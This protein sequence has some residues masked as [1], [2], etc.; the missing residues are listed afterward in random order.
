M[1]DNH[2]QSPPG[3]KMFRL[4][5]A[6]S[7]ST[8]FAVIIFAF[9]LS[10]SL[11]A[12]PG[13]D[14]EIPLDLKEWR[15]VSRGHFRGYND[16]RDLFQIVHPM[17]PAAAGDYGRMERS[18]KLP[19]GAEAPYTL[20]FYVSDNI[21]GEVP[22]RNVDIRKGH[23]YGQV[24]LDGK[25]IWSRDIFVNS[26][27][28][29]PPYTWVDLTPYVKPG[30]L[31]NLSFQ[32][33]QEVDSSS[34]MEGDIIK[35]GVYAG[36]TR[37]Y[38]PLP[39][40]KY[41]TWSYW[42]DFSIFCGEIQE[43]EKM[44]PVFKPRIKANDM[45]DIYKQGPVEEKMVSLA[46]EKGE[47]LD[48]SWDWPVS[49]GIPLPSGAVRD[50]SGLSLAMTGGKPARAVFTPMGRWPD[51]SL[52][53]VLLDVL[54]GK[55]ERGNYRLL[56]GG[57]VNAPAQEAKD[58]IVKGNGKLEMGNGIVKVKWNIGKDGRPNDLEIGTEGGRK[59][60]RD[61]EPYM[62]VGSRKLKAA[63]KEG[64]WLSGSSRRS[65]MEISGELVADDGFRYG[66]CRMRIA[67][68]AD[69]P[70]LRVLYTVV[71]ER[72]E[73]VP[74]D[75]PDTDK[76][77][78]TGGLV[79]GTRP[80]TAVVDTYGLMLKCDVRDSRISDDGWICAGSGSGWV[81]GYL[82]YF[83]HIWPAGLKTDENGMDFILFKKGDPRLKSYSTYPGEAKTHEIWLA[84][85]GS[86][87]GDNLCESL[88]KIAETP[89][90]LDTSGLI[91]ESFVWGEMPVISESENREIYAMLVE[92]ALYPYYSN[93]LKG[94][95]HYG[96]YAGGLN[97][98]WNGL[99]S[100][101]KLYAMT[102]E[103]KWYD[104][105]ERSIR[106]YMDICTIHW[107]PDGKKVGGKNR[108]VDK[109]LAV[110]LVHQN[111]DPLF[112]HWNMTGD[113]EGYRL[114]RMNADL[115]MGDSEFI[116]M[117][118]Q[119]ADRQQGWPLM[120]MVRAWQET[121]DEKY[122]GHARRI[123][124][125]ALGYMED[126]R[127]AYIRVHGS[128]SHM[129][130]VPF[131][132]G[133]LCSG[134]K[135]YHFW[136]GDERAACT[137]AQVSESVFAEMHDPYY[138]KTLPDIDYYYSPNP[139]LRGNDGHT[140]TTHLNLNIVAAQ[141]Y[142]AYITGDSGLADIA[143]RS[144]RAYVRKGSW[145]SLSYLYSLHAALF[146]LKKAPV[147][148]RSM[149][150][151][152]NP[153]W[154]YEAA[155]REIWL[156]IP[157]KAPLA[158]KVRWTLY[159]Q[160]FQRG[161]S[162]S[163]WKSYVEKNN[164]K[165]R[166][167]LL[168][169]SGKEISSVLLDFMKSPNGKSVNINVPE[170]EPGFYRLLAKGA[171]A[172]PVQLVLQD[173]SPVDSG[174]G[175]P[176]DRWAVNGGEEYFFH[177]PA[178]L[179]ELAVRYDLLTP[180]EV[181]NVALLDENGKILKEDRYSG[182]RALEWKVQLPEGSAGKVWSLR[183]NGGGNPV[184]SISGVR[185]V[186]LKKDALF[187]PFGT[188]PSGEGKDIPPAPAGMTGSIRRI[189]AGEYFGIP[190][191]EKKGEMSY[192]NVNAS[193]GTIEFWMMIDGNDRDILSMNFLKFG[194]MSFYHRAGVGAYYN[195]GK[196]F[197]QSGFVFMPR[198][199][200]RVA[201]TW[202]TGNAGKSPSMDLFVNGISMMG[203]MQ[204][205]LPRDTGDWTGNGLRIGS[206]VPI[207]VAGLRILD[208]YLEK[209]SKGKVVTDGNTAGVLYR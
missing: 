130:I 8:R 205:P 150:I 163:F 123:V 165:G 114:G 48:G 27:L 118:E 68:H 64:R 58:F 189:P 65:E 89:V 46:L 184:L 190:R 28:S 22:P 126:R 87:P 61:I 45:S 53:W 186:S 91:R 74:E 202:R 10:Q 136:T 158:I 35:L 135:N 82:R 169:A 201:L 121:G 14:F 166:L 125:I 196:G 12:A 132:S 199:W 149:S 133:I 94:I 195:L 101:Y 54:I 177:V 96:G 157:R 182:G 16:R 62:F 80:L 78:S 206:N 19:E 141:A 176:V 185:M 156:N 151:D 167:V 174:W 79:G 139:Y 83:R 60:V 147:T 148:D 178:G 207:Y 104:M 1:P 115:L 38:D 97:F 134:L 140:L 146:W 92:K 120:A 144:W 66:S 84:V 113:Y 198:E 95:R 191:G 59:T 23:R 20:R 55:N 99:D 179:K 21:Y 143:W 50:V 102:G 112:D 44:V 105:A 142:A 26:P 110:Y 192:E 170:V 124:D 106:H 122:L 117:T 109:F 11:S 15:F 137:I 209:D 193:G 70:L 73:A 187:L 200:Y 32:L 131:M 111:T 88:S 2:F 129:G 145:G 36:T 188:E 3:G 42:G 67:M 39:R 30:R 138:S 57:K 90:R 181:K 56:Y 154:K 172:L 24:L 76:V 203:R 152:F 31:F 103:R 168:D 155:S 37:P 183:N 159:E 34:V 162:L 63:W 107:S 33:W 77:K 29:D 9:I 51:G 71:N 72:G 18:L 171:D 69:S 119:R 108:S 197:F 116:M 208:T 161:Q 175:L 128:S 40:E 4:T 98:Y 41:S 43:K 180:W 164:P 173:I 204:T 93:T 160:P 17:E 153:L 25:V 5:H 85:S 127:G 81:T 86:R 100:M 194:S 6:G 13:K 7:I 75:R 49:Q 47:L 52:R